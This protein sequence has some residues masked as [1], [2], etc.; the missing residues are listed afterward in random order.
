MSSQTQ[1]NSTHTPEIVHRPVRR[2]Q[3]NHLLAI[4]LLVAFID[5]VLEY[6]GALNLIPNFGRR[7]KPDLTLGL[8]KPA[9]LTDV[10]QGKWASPYVK[11]LAQK[12]I[13][14]GYPNREFRPNQPVTRAEFATMLQVAFNLA[15]T[16]SL[17]RSVQA[18]FDPQ[19]VPA[20]GGFRDVSSEYW[21]AAFGYASHSRPC[22]DPIK[23]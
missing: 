7:G 3:G 5:L 11:D 9:Q 20:D 13:V 18:F 14:K 1:T 21:A 8:W 19:A 22:F 23:P 10:S 17:V 6:F 12:G 2:R 16:L 15:P 4:L